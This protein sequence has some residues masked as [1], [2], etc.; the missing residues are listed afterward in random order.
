MAQA[1]TPPLRLYGL[2]NCDTC[3]KARA[4]LAAAGVAH[5]F[6]DFKAQGPSDASLRHWLAAL[7]PD[8]LINRRGTTWRNLDPAAQHAAQRAAT[9]GAA[10]Q[11]DTALPLLRTQPSLI[12]RPLV[13]WPNG[14]VSV[15]FDVA[16]WEL[17]VVELTRPR[18]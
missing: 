9:Q 6:H 13:E 5:S 7:G 11:A 15:G 3:K 12:K 1:P 4:W 2:A 17:A 8:A 16:A 14:Q 10:A 18:G